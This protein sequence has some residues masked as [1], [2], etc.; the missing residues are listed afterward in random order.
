MVQEILV[1][2]HGIV[3]I[4]GKGPN[5]MEPYNPNRTIGELIQTMK[6]HKLGEN[7][8]RIEI[9]K[10]SPGNLSKY[11]INDPYWAHNTT[12]AEYLQYMGGSNGRYLMLVY[13]VV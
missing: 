9:F 1:Y 11:D 2:W 7:N 5:W 12:L 6:T 8:K 10:I 13:V 4:A 3:G